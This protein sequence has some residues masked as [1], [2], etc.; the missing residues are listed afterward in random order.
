VSRMITALED[1]KYVKFIAC[2]KRALNKGEELSCLIQWIKKP[3]FGQ[4]V[5]IFVY[6]TC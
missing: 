3:L 4:G 2:Q 5:V 6:L 1:S